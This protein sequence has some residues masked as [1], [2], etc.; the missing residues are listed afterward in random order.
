M[1]KLNPVTAIAS[2]ILYIFIAFFVLDLLLGID[3]T[4]LA[5]IWSYS[6]SFANGVIIISMTLLTIITVW[7]Y[8]Y[9]NFTQLTTIT[10][11]KIHQTILQT[12]LLI[13][14]IA[15][16]FLANAIIFF[17]FDYRT[18]FEYEY[19]IYVSLLF[20][21]SA[22]AQIFLLFGLFKQLTKKKYLLQ[23]AS[24]I[25]TLVVLF[26]AGFADYLGYFMYADLILITTVGIYFLNIAL[27]TKDFKSNLVFALGFYLLFAIPTLMLTD[28]EVY[29]YNTLVDDYTHYSANP[30]VKENEIDDQRLGPVEVYSTQGSELYYF[31]V[32][33]Y[34]YR[35]QLYDNKSHILNI[36]EPGTIVAFQLSFEKEVGYFYGSGNIESRDGELQFCNESI[37]YEDAKA[38][39]QCIPDE[40]IGVVE[41]L[42]TNPFNF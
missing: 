27:I 13:L 22:L 1:N 5:P 21:V 41:Y 26:I 42:A 18:L 28:N 14:I 37:A 25:V 23:V 38:N 8:N 6:A 19:H 2:Y 4:N 11:R 33:N 36:T 31:S 15:F 3:Q 7:F 40:V 17:D 12:F 34:E 24:T 32:G 39:S 10:S 29:D 20:A 16:T 35:Y 9:Q 30:L